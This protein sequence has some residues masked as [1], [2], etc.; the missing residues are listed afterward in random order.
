MD[1]KSKPV[2]ETIRYFAGA[3]CIISIVGF[4]IC[5]GISFIFTGSISYTLVFPMLFILIAAYVPAVVAVT[6]HPPDFICWLE[7]HL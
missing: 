5:L 4:L 7:S 3:I 6:G 2:N 1:K